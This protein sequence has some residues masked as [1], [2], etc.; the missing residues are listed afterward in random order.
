MDSN[1]QAMFTLIITSFNNMLNQMLLGFLYPFFAL[2]K[3]TICQLNTLMA[4]VDLTGYKV[5]IG[6]PEIQVTHT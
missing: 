2:Q 5:T 4:F 3:T 1:F 6:M